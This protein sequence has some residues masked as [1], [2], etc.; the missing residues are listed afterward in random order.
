[1]EVGVESELDGG[2]EF[3]KIDLCTG[4]HRCQIGGLTPA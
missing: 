4:F 2:V 3:S 1:M